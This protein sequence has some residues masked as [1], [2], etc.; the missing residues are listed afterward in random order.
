MTK[1]G[2]PDLAIFGRALRRKRDA[3]DGATEGG[4][5][6]DASGASGKSLAFA[7][8]GC[9]LV[10][11]LPGLK[12]QIVAPAGRIQTDSYH[13]L[14]QELIANNLLK[15]SEDGK[16]I[17][18]NALG[19]EHFCSTR[20]RPDETCSPAKGGP[21]AF[22]ATLKSA[23]DKSFLKSDMANAASSVWEYDNGRILSGISPD[24]RNLTVAPVRGMGQQPRLLLTGEP[25]FVLEGTVGVRPIKAVLGDA[26]MQSLSLGPKRISGAY[27][28]NKPPMVLCLP[29][30]ANQ[31]GCLDELAV[32]RAGQGLF[33]W[34][35]RDV[36]VIEKA[37]TPQ[38]RSVKIGGRTIRTSDSPTIEQ[39]R[40][41]EQVVVRW[42]NHDLRFRLVD[43]AFQLG[44]LP[45]MGGIA[46]AV[47][48]SKPRSDVQTSIRAD[49]HLA[50]QKVLDELKALNEDGNT[51][52]RASVTLMD[53]WTGEIV[54]LPT[55]PHR[56][57]QLNSAER[58]FRRSW[59]AGN[60]AF[61]PMVVG[62]VAK[63]LFAA[64]LLKHYPDLAV[65]K[66]T[67]PGPGRIKQVEGEALMS[68]GSPASVENLHGT[69]EFGFKKFIVKSNN[70]FALAMM[71]RASGS[72][73]G[74]GLAEVA[75]WAD[76]FWAMNCA[77]ASQVKLP[78]DNPDRFSEWFAKGKCSPTLWPGLGSTRPSALAAAE[79]STFSL[80]LENAVMPTNNLPQYYMNVLGSGRS[81]WPGIA[82]AQAFTR[83]VT[84][85][86]VNARFLS[87]D[88][89]YKLSSLFG[90]ETTP[91]VKLLSNNLLSGMKDVVM[92]NAG[93]GNDLASLFASNGAYAKFDVYA[94]TGTFK[95]GSSAAEKGYGCI[96]KNL[97]AGVAFKVNDGKFT[98]VP[99]R[100]AGCDLDRDLA[101]LVRNA[102]DRA[103]FVALADEETNLVRNMPSLTRIT[104]G[105]GNALV[106]VLRCKK[107]QQHI[108]T[109]AINVQAKVG[110]RADIA[111]AQ[112]VLMAP[113]V[114]NWITTGCS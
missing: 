84:L 89:I 105:A 106:L 101:E 5:Q 97:E 47:L 96:L 20:P 22:K 55:F 51:S 86:E 91:A 40:L 83:I 43:R 49:V 44:D 92:D 110:K 35:P 98:A 109:I 81:L 18:F 78:P 57:D 23:K 87:V 17:E 85:N 61:Q 59:L 50:A 39:L 46:A 38:E 72:E 36:G 13:N 31:A 74:K 32:I 68:G 34:V 28:E 67:A 1:P 108:R 19:I 45:G 27:D 15:R 58:Q 71:K 99:R 33:L 25:R 69:E 14:V 111:Y 30:G 41:G 63:V 60:M 10:G 94:K 21:E 42:D 9:L 80:N 8:G 16:K 88:T 112:S 102:D 114:R 82:L 107:R 53:G 54:A 76:E 70:Y 95:I 103:A 65:R 100:A 12:A 37:G 3:M 62:S 29:F 64:P 48:A 52:V 90:K 79:L 56:E 2:R 4:R 73:S 24:A 26:A 7:L 11:L 93:S 75:E 77:V 104:E 113:S 66:Y 6:G